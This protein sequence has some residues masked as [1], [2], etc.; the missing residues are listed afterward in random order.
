MTAWT[1][2]DDRLADAFEAIDEIDWNLDVIV[3]HYKH[4]TLH[5]G[6]TNFLDRKKVSGHCFPCDQYFLPIKYAL[7]LQIR[8]YSNNSFLFEI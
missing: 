6:I 7:N 1:E 3:I 5:Q 8:Y 4:H 2:N